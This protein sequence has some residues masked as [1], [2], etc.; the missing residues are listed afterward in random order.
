MWI[1]VKLIRGLVH[2][3]LRADRSQ[4]RVGPVGVRAGLRVWLAPEA[5]FPPTVR[6]LRYGQ[7]NESWGTRVYVPQPVRWSCMCV[8]RKDAVG[9]VQASL[10]PTWKALGQPDLLRSPVIIIIKST[11]R[12][13]RALVKECFISPS[14][15]TPCQPPSPAWPLSTTPR[16]TPP[17]GNHLGHLSATLSYISPFDRSVAFPLLSV[18]RCPSTALRTLKPAVGYLLPLAKPADRENLSK[19]ALERMR[20]GLG[21]ISSVVCVCDSIEASLRQMIIKCIVVS[22]ILTLQWRIRREKNFK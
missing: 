20:N 13:V 7:R 18:R 11:L 8:F 6:Y 9:K 17:T 16:A 12:A 1:I 21:V 19:S 4:H 15:P 10:Q 22:I 3:K 14:P 2:T 5:L